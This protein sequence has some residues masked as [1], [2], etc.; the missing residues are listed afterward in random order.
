MGAVARLRGG[1]RADG[2]GARASPD[3][4]PLAPLH[5]TAPRVA[6]R[7]ATGVHRA[8]GR[9]R[10]A[11][12]GRDPGRRL[13]RAGPRVAA[14]ARPGRAAP[15]D[16]FGARGHVR[17]PAAGRVA[18]RARL[19]AGPAHLARPRRLRLDD[20]RRRPLPG[21]VHPGSGALGSLLDR[22]PGPAPARLRDRAGPALS[23]PVPRGRRGH[24][25][26]A[27]PRHRGRRAHRDDGRRRREVRL[28]ADDLGALL[29]HRA[30]GWTA[31]SRRS[32]R[33]PTG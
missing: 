19:G 10:R 13:L 16:G 8:P 26:P 25:L 31:S 17:A 5:R 30:A 4:A 1:V 3:R 12:P 28:V 7:G 32:R 6:A 11:R 24:R 22:R 21:G 20:R 18:R 14:G 33:T 2:R 23:D 29:G 9:A 15:S 27:R